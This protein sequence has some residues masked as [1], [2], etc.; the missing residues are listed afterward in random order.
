[1]GLACANFML[2]HGS[3]LDS[4][5]WSLTSHL[6]SRLQAA[7]CTPFSSTNLSCK[8]NIKEDVPKGGARFW[9]H[10][11]LAAPMCNLKRITAP[12]F[13]V[14]VSRFLLSLL[15]LGCH[16]QCLVPSK[17]CEGAETGDVLGAPQKWPESWCRAKISKSVEQRC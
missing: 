8:Q 6:S 15:A 5:T 11:L 17:N 4:R 9:L 3:L 2:I 10:K 1:M 14:A 7:R 13:L 12:S 16:K